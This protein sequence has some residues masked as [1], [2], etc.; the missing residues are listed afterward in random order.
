MFLLEVFLNMTFYILLSSVVSE[1]LGIA[2]VCPIIIA[3]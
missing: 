1:S 3:V 2:R